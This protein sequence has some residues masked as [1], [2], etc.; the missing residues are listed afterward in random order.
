MRIAS[1]LPSAT[2]IVYALGLDDRLVAVSHECDYPP[3]AREK[4]VVVHSAVDSA[5]L[6]SGE[7]DQRV[8]ALLANGESLYAIDERQLRAL[9]PELILTQDLCQVCAPSGNLVTDVLRTLTPAP[10]VLWLT[11]RSLDDIL[12]NIQMVGVATGCAERA[13]SMI[14]DLRARLTTVAECV[15]NEPRPRVSFIEWVDPIYCAGHWIPEMIEQAGGADALGRARGESTR[16]EWHD[17]MR[18]APE[19]LIVAPCG[20]DVKRSLDDARRLT[21]LPGWRELPAVRDGRV[22]PVDANAYF[23]RP[24]PRVVDGTE[25]LAHLFHPALVGWQGPDDAYATLGAA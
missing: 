5:A 10:N 22:Y 15:R 1:F 20:F 18:W 25:L 16:V 13:E 8:R 4:P 6:S 14:A 7:I 24:G 19:V 12:E 2:E 23:A 17:I 3:I 11:P 9:S 21:A